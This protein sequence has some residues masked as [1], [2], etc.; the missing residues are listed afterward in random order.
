MNRA[1]HLRAVI[2]EYEDSIREHLGD[3]QYE[4]LLAGIQTLYQAEDFTTVVRAVH[5]LRVILSPLPGAHPVWSVLNAL[6]AS[7]SEAPDEGPVAATGIVQE[8]R[9]V[10]RGAAFPLPEDEPPAPDSPVPPAMESLMGS[11]DVPEPGPETVA[12]IAEVQRRLLTAPSLSAE[13]AKKRCAGRP[14]RELI[15]LDDPVRGARYPAFQFTLGRGG[16]PLPVVRQVNRILLAEVDPWGAADWWLSGNAWLGGP[17]VT[18][19][20]VLPDASLAG[21]AQALVEGD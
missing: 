6:L 20:G 15:R 11:T 19:L 12:V 9:P 13:E 16:A 18:L 7:S 1:E 10:D 3:E 8:A 5:S 14:P 21:A 2:G 17:P 4:G